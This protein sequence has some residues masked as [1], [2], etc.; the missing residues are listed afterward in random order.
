MPFFLSGRRDK[1]APDFKDGDGLGARPNI[2]LE[3]FEQP[4]DQARPQ[5]DVIFA[6]RI[7]QRYRLFAECGGASRDQFGCARFSEKRSEDHTSELQSQSNLVCRLLLEK[8]KNTKPKKILSQLNKSALTTNST[9]FK[10]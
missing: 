5:R 1:R 6:Q 2:S 8:K 9:H 4:A 7:S 10:N 3:H